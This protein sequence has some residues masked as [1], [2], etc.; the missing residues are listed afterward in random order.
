MTDDKK[1][2]AKRPLLP[3]LVAGWLMIASFATLG[4][5][6]EGLHAYK[7]PQ[8]LDVGA[9]PRRLVWTLAHAHGVLLGVVQVALALT[10]RSLSVDFEAGWAWT[11]VIGS[12]LVPVG[13][14]LG[15]FG[16]AGGD[17]GPGVLLVPIGAVAVI[18][19]IGRFAVA[20]LVATRQ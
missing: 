11:L 3:N 4:L 19:S 7:W 8:Y 13:F 16:V 9:E 5:V 6:L 18:A 2:T 1:T 20:V 15:G 14:F 10:H 12:I 17:P